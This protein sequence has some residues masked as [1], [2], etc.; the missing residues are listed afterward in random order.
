M[1]MMVTVRLIMLNV[2]AKLIAIELNVEE[3]LIVKIKLTLW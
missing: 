3:H 1:K 2:T